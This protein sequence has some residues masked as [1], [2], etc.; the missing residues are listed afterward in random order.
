VTQQAKDATT[1]KQTKGEREKMLDIL[2]QRRKCLAEMGQKVGG[3]K[4]KAESKE[5]PEQQT[6]AAVSV[7]QHGNKEA[8]PATT[9]K[10][11]KRERE[12]MLA[13]LRQRRK[14]LA[15]NGQ[16]PAKS[17]AKPGGSKA[18]KPMRTT[19]V[20][21]PKTKTVKQKPKAKAK[22][23]KL[24]AK[25]AKKERERMPARL[26][27]RKERKKTETDASKAKQTKKQ[28]LSDK[29]A[30]KGKKKKG[31]GVFDLLRSTVLRPCNA[32][33]TQQSPATNTRSSKV[34]RECSRQK[35]QSPAAAGWFRLLSSS[36]FR[37]LFVAL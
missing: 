37:L 32:Q 12:K 24:T 36:S 33:Q 21:K 7:G 1:S 19:T 4:A 2:R 20:M 6:G 28:D 27:K 9:T 17:K 13:R 15:D 26:R 34:L 11:T 16:K 5:E 14:R 29:K 22:A 18:I 10:Q 30:T 35:Q 31:P 3:K 25:E 8:T 23:M